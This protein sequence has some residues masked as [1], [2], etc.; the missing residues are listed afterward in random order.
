[1]PAAVV[2]DGGF[3]VFGHDR[4]IVRQHLVQRL[5]VKFR[6]LGDGGVEVVHVS[7]VMLVVMDFHRLLVDVGSSASDGNG[8]GGS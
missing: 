3:D 7:R 8:S 4:Q 1:M 6:M 5:A 2:A